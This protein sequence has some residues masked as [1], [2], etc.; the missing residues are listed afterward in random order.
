MKIYLSRDSI[1]ELDAFPRSE[2]KAVLK[3]AWKEMRK[4]EKGFWAY[5]LL[6]VLIVFGLLII[7]TSIPPLLVNTTVAGGL[8]GLI[9]QQFYFRRVVRYIKK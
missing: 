4:K 5:P 9:I 8:A 3:S 7:L 6:A 2:R 1:E